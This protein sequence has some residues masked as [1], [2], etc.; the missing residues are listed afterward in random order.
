[1]PQ[2]QRFGEHGHEI[3]VGASPAR[4]AAAPCGA[5]TDC[6]DRRQR[7]TDAAPPHPPAIRT[8]VPS[9]SLDTGAG[10][11]AADELRPARHMDALDNERRA[12]D[13]GV[14]DV[15]GLGGPRLQSSGDR[16][17]AVGGSGGRS[18]R[19]S[20]PR[21]APRMGFRA[22]AA[23]GRIRP[24]A[25]PARPADDRVPAASPTTG[26][27]RARKRRLTSKPRAHRTHSGAID[28]L[29]QVDRHFSPLHSETITAEN[30]DVVIQGGR[31]MVTSGRQNTLRAEFSKTWTVSG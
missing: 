23:A 29:V 2:R 19:E 4:R 16:G 28:Q 7:S 6:R 5:R 30:H 11:I 27:P 9:C 12:D 10:P 21:A 1:V 26:H 17:P 3:A 31:Q 25:A 18:A 15:N 14:V 8:T 22:G 24:T 13:V 20:K